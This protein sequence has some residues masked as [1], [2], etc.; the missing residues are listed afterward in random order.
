M[1]FNKKGLEKIKREKEAWERE[2]KKPPKRNVSFTTVSGMDVPPLVTPAGLNGFNYANDLG[3]PGSYPFT[4]GVYSTMYHGKLW[5]M[6]QFAGFATPEDTNRRFKFLLGQGQ[7]GLSTAFDMPTLMGY[8]CDHPRAMGEVGKEGVSVS[9]LADM[10]VLFGG[11]RLDEVTTSMTINCTATV[12]LAMYLVVAEKQGVSWDKLDGTIQNDMLKEFI[13]QR[14]WICPP[15]PSVKIIVDMIEFCAKSV[16]KWHPVSI[17]GYH[18]REAGST[19]VQELAFTLAGGIGYAQECIE[20]GLK[21]DDFAPRLSFFFNVHNDFLEEVAKFRA[22]RRMWAKIMRER[23]GATNPKSW[24]L[25]THAQTA[26]CSLTAQQPLNNIIRVAI[27]A[28]AAVLGGTQS[29]HTNSMDE[30]LS[31]PTEEAV[32]V[33]LRTQQIIAEES[34]VVNS[35][36]PLGGSYLIESLTN[37][38]EKEAFDY[39][40]RIDELGGIIKAIDIGFPQKEIADAA[41]KY[42]Q[43]LDRGEKVIVGVNKYVVPEE[44]KIPI[45][46]IDEEVDRNQRERLGEIMSRRN[47]KAV[48]SGLENIARA[49]RDGKNLMPHII[50]AVRE[51]ATVGEISD[52]FREVYGVYRDPGYF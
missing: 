23:F 29:L 28:L 39:I 2:Y 35:I 25:R 41:Y 49:A 51:Y 46:K 14:E 17:S 50:N 24:I 38:M 18:I 9:S 15:R 34:G 4:R 13:A 37:T 47:N 16:P 48:K 22:A 45:L 36:D 5:T 52:V 26:G 43:E 3:F 44:R 27:Q 11:I 42:Q 40:N 31:L 30:T 12:I 32:T 19:A 10:E 21:V 7:T 20:R 33:A 8:D 1:S 6:R